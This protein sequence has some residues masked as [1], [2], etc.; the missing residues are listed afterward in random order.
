MA[1]CAEK[2][3]EHNGFKL[4]IQ[5]I[6][7]KST[8]IIVGENGDMKQKAN[9]LVTEVF[10]TELIGEG[11]LSTFQ[12]AHQVL[13]EKNCIVIP[14]K[15][16]IY[17]QL[18]ES[19]TMRQWNRINPIIDPETE[20]ILLKPPDIIN[21]CPG[22]LA[23]HDIQLSQ[24]P[25]ESF[26]S[27][28]TSQPIFTFDWSGKKPIIFNEVNSVN[29]TA[30]ASGTAHAV[31]MWWELAMDED[32]EIILSCAPLW[33]HPNGQLNTNEEKNSLSSHKDSKIPWRDHWMQAVYYLPTEMPIEINEKITLI[34]CHDEFSL[35]FD[36]S[37][38]TETNI[39]SLQ[40][41]ACNC[42]LHLAYS[43]T[44]IAQLNDEEKNNKYMKILKKY[45]LPDTEC[46]CLS[47]SC[48]IGL[49]SILF[50][51]KKV[52]M[53]EPN[54]LSR[55]TI[56]SFIDC[57]N[58]TDKVEMIDSIDELCW[59]K[60]SNRLIIGD[61][62]YLNSIF[63]WDNF[64]FWYLIST[65]T[66]G[67]L[68]IPMAVRIRGIIVEFKDLYKIRA[69]VGVC[70]GF[71]LMDFD[72]LVSASSKISDC[73]VE[74]HS[75]WEY[76]SWALSE[77]FDIATYKFNED[78]NSASGKMYSGEISISKNGICNGIA[79]WIDWYLDSETIH[80]TGP[81]ETIIPGEI[82]SWGMCNRQGVYL[83]KDIKSV[84]EHDVLKWSFKYRHEND[85][86]FDFKYHFEE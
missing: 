65:R 25:Y 35:W 4:Q 85:N 54:S 41:P 64:R 74:V 57:N 31:F 82:I 18:V 20:K 67:I 16:T 47:D 34:G 1:E 50:G 56:K 61:P 2:I 76:P 12:H 46:L 17:G 5:L 78:F 59:T 49:T 10:D 23:L 51:A 29:S 9:I 39:N 6:K 86:Y 68:T 66:P 14:C 52:I 60:E 28:L 80:S 11:A 69:S 71:Q 7:K 33:E 84:T 45:I 53:Y 38:S 15:A 83:L 22:S 43:R 75:L 37:K 63:P 3:I 26:T 32:E 81:L 62:Y 19:W 21:S 58:L 8:Q 42:S 36:I 55:R 70:E 24:L 48:L 77:P 44:R 30:I 73:P 40:S 27:L 13:L 72:E 79:L